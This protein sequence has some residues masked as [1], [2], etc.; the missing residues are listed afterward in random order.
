[1]ASASYGGKAIALSCWVSEWV[2][3]C[4]NRIRTTYKPSTK[5]TELCPIFLALSFCSFRNILVCSTLGDH[6][7]ECYSELAAWS[8]EKSCDEFKSFWFKNQA[9]FLRHLWGTCKRIIFQCEAT[10]VAEMRNDN[11]RVPIL[12]QFSP[13][14]SRRYLLEVSESYRRWWKSHNLFGMAREETKFFLAGIS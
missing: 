7:F 6:F 1:M 2:S 3:E 13:E 8:H 14:V 4:N 12:T 10:L 11:D 5:S 9:Q